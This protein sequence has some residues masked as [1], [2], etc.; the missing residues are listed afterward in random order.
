MITPKTLLTLAISVLVKPRSRVKGIGHHAH[1]DIAHPVERD[2]GQNDQR[3]A[4]V[5]HKEIHERRY[6]GA[7]EPRGQSMPPAQNRSVI[8]N[9]R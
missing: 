6:Y 7:R 8:L 9:C 1:G 3:H 2:Q 4:A 5:A